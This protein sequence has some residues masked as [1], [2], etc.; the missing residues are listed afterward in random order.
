MEQSRRQAGDRIGAE[1]SDA[2]ALIA[3]I[4]T[5]RQVAGY[6]QP[7]EDE[8]DDVI[9]REWI[10]RVASLRATVFAA[11]IRARN[12]QASQFDWNILFRHFRGNEG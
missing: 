5:K 12:D 6:G 10:G 11:V 4:T 7:A 2:F 9:N 1:D 8:R 3:A